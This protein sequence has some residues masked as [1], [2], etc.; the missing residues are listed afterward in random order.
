MDQSDVFNLVKVSD[1]SKTTLKTKAETKSEEDKI[2]HHQEFG[3]N[4]FNAKKMLMMMLFKTFLSA[5][6]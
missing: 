5:N 2:L 4:Y 3:S 1:L 6:T